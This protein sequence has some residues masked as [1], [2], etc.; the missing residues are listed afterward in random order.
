MTN[1]ELQAKSFKDQNE[2][3]RGGPGE[4]VGSKP[5]NCREY[6]ALKNYLESTNA[7]VEITEMLEQFAY[8]VD[9][10]LSYYAHQLHQ[11]SKP[12][13][14]PRLPRRPIRPFG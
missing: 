5:H 7:P 2:Y 13:P 10:R 1:E 14:V 11:K 9:S 12:A 8:F 3:W 6:W 4:R